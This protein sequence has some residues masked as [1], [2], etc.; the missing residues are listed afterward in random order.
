MVVVVSGILLRLDGLT[1]SLWLDEFGTY[2]VVEGDFVTMLER[3]WAFQGQ[4]P[5]YYAFPW[6]SRHVFG[7]SELALRLPSLLF[8]CLSVL[9]VYSTGR[10]IEGSTAGLYA[11]ALFWLAVPSVQ[12]TVEARPYSLVMFTVAAALAGFSYAVR[13]GSRSARLAWIVGGAAVAWSHYLHYP[14]VLGLFVAYAVLPA[15]RDRYSMRRFTV[16]GVAQFALVSLCAPQILAL[17]ARRGTLSWISDVNYA[18]LLEPIW[19]LMIGI[20]IGVAQ[21][22][23]RED[24]TVAQALRRALLVCAAVQLTAIA[25]ASLAGMNLLSGRYVTSILVPAVVFVG[26]TLARAK[27]EGV[28]AIVVVFAV[29]TGAVLQSTKEGRGSFSGN[30]YQDW[31]TAVDDLSARIGHGREALV[32]FRSGFVE[33]DLI[34]LGNPPPAVFAPL[35]SPGRGPFET[36]VVPLNFRWAHPDRGEYFDRVIAPRVERSTGFFVIG[37]RG[38]ATVGNYMTKVVEWVHSRWPA[39][40]RVRRTTYGGIELIE[41]LSTLSTA[42]IPADKVR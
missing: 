18:V 22:A 16:D 9:A 32:L 30:G 15:L 34:P 4:S 12:H 24:A 13:S 17:M 14:L 19:P 29:A 11:A 40:Y 36:A 37:A 1:S 31:R 21:L 35:R 7:D 20:A 28:I 23:R 27:A 39:R 42:A 3:A 5:L 41:F 6:I 33:E 2:W 10:A 25:G 8:G 26:T 38:D